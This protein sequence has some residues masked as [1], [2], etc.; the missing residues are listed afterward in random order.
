MLNKEFDKKLNTNKMEAWKCFKQICIKFL[1]SHKTE[2]FENVVANLLYS[3]NVLGCKMCI[4]YKK[5]G[6]YFR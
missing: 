4:F 3:Y 1:G 2:N 5:F 6:R